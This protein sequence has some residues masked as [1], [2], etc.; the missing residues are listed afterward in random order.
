M[1][2]TTFDETE[3]KAVDAFLC[4]LTDKELSVMKLAFPQVTGWPW[5]LH[6]AIKAE[7][8]HRVSGRL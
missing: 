1:S 6:P 7:I 2:Q 4:I 8:A 5:R 3:R